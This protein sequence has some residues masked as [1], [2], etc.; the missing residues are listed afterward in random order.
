MARRRNKLAEADRTRRHRERVRE[1]VRN[2]KVSRGCVDCGENHPACLQFHHR[3]PAMK[4]ANINRLVITRRSLRHLFD[5]IDK[6]DVLCANCHAKRHW[7]E[8]A[9][10][11]SDRPMPP[12]LEL[13]S[14]AN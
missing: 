2:I 6:C 5:E 10:V 3:D 11:Q 8:S 12:I 7:D 1:M 13:L 9:I 4:L 14:A